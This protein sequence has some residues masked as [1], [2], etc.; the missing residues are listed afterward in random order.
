MRSFAIIVVSLTTVVNYLPKRKKRG[1]I[2]YFQHTTLC[3]LMALDHHFIIARMASRINPTNINPEPTS[4][5]FSYCGFFLRAEKQ[6]IIPTMR[7][8][9]LAASSF[10]ILISPFVQRILKILFS[11]YYL[12]YTP[13]FESVNPEVHF[14]K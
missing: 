7:I 11:I 6:T 5:P 4:M 9:F 10:S 2:D 1:N 3:N 14:I 12:H 8:I 13:L